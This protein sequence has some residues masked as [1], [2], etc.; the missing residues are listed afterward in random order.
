MGRI[1]QEPGRSCV[2]PTESS[3][4]YRA[5]TGPGPAGVSTA[6]RPTKRRQLGRASQSIS[7]PVFGAGSRSAFVVLRTLANAA[8]ADPIEGREALLLQNRSGETWQV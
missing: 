2:R 4:W 7:E 1:A 3:Q 5:R 6:R 8:Q